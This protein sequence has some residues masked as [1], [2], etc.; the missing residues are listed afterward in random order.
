MECQRHLFDI[1][2]DIAY[3]NCA[4]MSPLLRSVR[5]AGF[6]GVAGKSRPWEIAPKDFFELPEE[7]RSLF[8]RLIGT[9]ADCVAFIP[10]ASYGI[11]TAARNVEVG[12]GSEIVL[13]AGEFPSNVYPWVERAREASAEI[14]FVAKPRD[15]D[16]TAALLAAMTPRTSVVSVPNVHWAEGAHV[17]LVAVRAR[18]DEVGCALVLDL[19]QSLGALRFD[20]SQV[21]PDFMACPTYK[22]LLGP[23]SMGFLYVAPEWHEGVPIEHG[24]ITRAGSEDFAR[25]VEYQDAFQPGARRY[26]VGERANFALMPMVRAALL[27]LIAWDPVT[28]S[29]TLRERTREIAERTS[30]LGYEAVPEHLR[31]PHYLGLTHPDGLPENVVARLARE[32]VYVSQRGQSLRVTPH[33]YNTDDDTGRLIEA[34][35]GLQR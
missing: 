35:A 11:G 5:A 29:E 6:D 32:Q 7:T 1:P 28:I 10:S 2:D 8:A 33:V 23:Y 27:Q 25:L 24:W 34:L 14:R 4:Y 22:W 18:A 19:S 9:T 20:V 12:A 30:G 21:R 31:A 17:D 15:L 16:W 13:L 3:L 26:D